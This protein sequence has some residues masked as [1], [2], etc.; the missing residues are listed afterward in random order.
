MDVD[1]Q[2]KR[3][4][5]VKRENVPNV[6]VGCS[7]INQSKMT[8][9]TIA[10]DKATKDDLDALVDGKNY[11]VKLQKLI[12]AYGGDSESVDEARIREIVR[13]EVRDVVVFEAL[14]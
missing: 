14:E 12:E 10:V 9:T 5:S 11:D 6:L 7:S 8:M 13:E 2:S 4:N 3:A 1:T